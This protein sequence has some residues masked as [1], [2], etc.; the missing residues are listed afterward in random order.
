MF[1]NVV[2]DNFSEPFQDASE[3]TWFAVCPSGLEV[4]QSGGSSSHT[5]AKRSAVGRVW[6]SLRSHPCPAALH[7][8]FLLIP[9]FIHT[10][11]TSAFNDRRMETRFDILIISEVI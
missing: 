7:L 8:S 11:L 2:V 10:P 1:K 6:G 9:S 5:S 4:Q 3:A